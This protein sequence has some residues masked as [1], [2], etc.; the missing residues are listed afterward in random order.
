VA[1]DDFVW[2]V[3]AE[4]HLAANKA[5]RSARAEALRLRTAHPVRTRL[6]RLLGAHT[7][8]RAFRVG[9][10]G[11]E[12][13]GARLEKLDG[14]R[15]LA[16]HDIVLNETGTNLDHL[17]IG[18]AGVFSLN[19][20]HHPKGKIVVT[21]RT[22]RLNGYRQN[23]LP[24]AV[25]E[26]KKVGRILTRAAGYDVGVT[27]VIVVMGAELEVRAA[28]DDVWVV[29]RRDIPKAFQRLTTVLPDERV[30]ELQRVAGRP[31]TWRAAQRS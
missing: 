21:K 20:K 26:A 18:P 9:A 28:P 19:T 12:T 3:K 24:V 1:N 30:R 27:P 29:R 17:V 8:E 15:W 6:A 25:N 10:A 14:S 5:G 16:L 7:D 23:Y 4:G 11:E 22:F 13:V 31:S 2:A